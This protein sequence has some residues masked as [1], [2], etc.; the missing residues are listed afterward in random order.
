M[1]GIVVLDVAIGLIFIYLILGLM[2]S[3][4]QEVVARWFKLRSG[5]LWSGIENLLKDGDGGDTS[6]ADKLYNHPLIKKLGRNGAKPSYIPSRTFTLALLDVI[7]VPGAK[8]GPLSEAKN[9]VNKLDNEDLKKTL[10]SL[11]NDV[12]GDIEETRIRI[13]TWFDDSMDRVAGW[14]SRQARTIMFLLAFGL[15]VALNVDSIVIA[16]TL[17]REPVLREAMVKSA[18]ARHVEGMPESEKNFTEFKDQLDELSLPIGWE[19]F[20]PEWEKERFFQAVFG[21]ILSALAISLGAPF[22]FDILGKF[23]SIRN[24]GR[25]PDRSQPKA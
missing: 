12:E 15:T 2:C 19:K 1:Q 4:L 6:L 16:K 18:Q 25:K 21:W 24:A 11:I 17:W 20:P 14:Y 7:K 9:S 22:W 3:A 10:S 23:L 5:N 8:G 13:E